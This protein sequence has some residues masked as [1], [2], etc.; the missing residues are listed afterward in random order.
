MHI[1]IDL[2]ELFLFRETTPETPRGWLTVSA[3]FGLVISGVLGYTLLDS[4]SR[5]DTSVFLAFIA[6]PLA[7]IFA[8]LHAVREPRDRWLCLSTFI[9]NG[10]AVLLA[11]ALSN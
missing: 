3:I 6:A 2:L 8:A 7:M 5:A 4:P 1:L 10:T 11:F 9:I